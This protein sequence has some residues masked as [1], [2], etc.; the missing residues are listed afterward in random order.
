MRVAPKHVKFLLSDAHKTK[1]LVLCYILAFERKNRTSRINL[2]SVAR[3]HGFKSVCSVWEAYH[4][5][6]KHRF[7]SH[8]ERPRGKRFLLQVFMGK[9][10]S[11]SRQITQDVIARDYVQPFLNHTT[12]SYKNDN[13][14]IR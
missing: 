6:L 14:I 7:I 4:Y 11:A 1:K 3:K 5:L 10:C 9:L 2:H 8:E 13:S 12:S